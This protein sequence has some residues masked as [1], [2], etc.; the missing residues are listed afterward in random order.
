MKILYEYIDI[1]NN[2]L[3][4]SNVIIQ[5]KPKVI[6]YLKLVKINQCYDNSFKI[7]IVLFLIH[8]K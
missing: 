2:I 4:Y 6:K 8:K 5:E 7:K 3:E 1:I